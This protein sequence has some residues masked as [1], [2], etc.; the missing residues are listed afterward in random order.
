MKKLIFIGCLFGVGLLLSA[1]GCSANKTPQ[2]Q[3]PSVQAQTAQASEN[4]Q[5]TESNESV[6]FDLFKKAIQRAVKAAR[7]A[8][9]ADSPVTWSQTANLW[10][11][12]IELMEAVPESSPNY[13]IGRQ[14]V[15]EYQASLTQARQNAATG[16]PEQISKHGGGLGDTLAVFES[17]YGPSSGHGVGKGFRCNAVTSACEVMAVFIGDL[18]MHIELLLDQKVSRAQAIQMATPLL[19]SDAKPLA[20]GDANE[21]IHLIRYESDS[22]AKVFPTDDNPGLLRVMVEHE[23]LQPNQAFRVVIGV[24]GDEIL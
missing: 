1:S 10:E 16:L 5:L 2:V 9:M 12:A 15:I 23:P 14:K 17:R 19:P 11:E 21:E 8:Q 13:A 4:D 22:L 3:A 6:A 20:G 7:I 18:A 24:G